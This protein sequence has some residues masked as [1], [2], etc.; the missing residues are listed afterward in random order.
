MA[1]R[2]D[3]CC[4]SLYRFLLVIFNTILLVAGLVTFILACVLKWGKGLLSKL[5]VKELDDVID[6][7]TID[8]VAVVVLIVGVALMV[9]S[10]VG[11]LGLC[12]LNKCLLGLYEVI[13]ILIFLVHLVGLL[14]FVFSKSSI[15]KEFGKGMSK[16]VNSLNGFNSSVNVSTTIECEA[17][18]A[19]SK[20]IT[21]CG[22]KG[23]SDFSNR[24][25][26]NN[27]CCA[28]NS[29][30]LKGCTSKLTTEIDSHANSYLVIPSGI[31]LVV[32]LI[33]IASTPLLSRSILKEA[34]Y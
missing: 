34:D 23:P 22:D 10:L 2:L 14:V 9:I 20:I 29:P 19:L 13:V 15:E 26:I 6:V 7:G 18:L 33:I 31:I 28:S 5:D 21:C 4:A 12:Y 24:T 11:I 27:L 1:K 8:V 16:L 30:T 25:E 32:E 17:M 3:N